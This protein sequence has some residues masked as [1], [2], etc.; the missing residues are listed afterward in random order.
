[1][2][3]MSVFPDLATYVPSHRSR[4]RWRGYDQSRLLAEAITDHLGVPSRTALT[5]TRS[6]RSQVETRDRTTCIRKVA[7]VFEASASPTIAGKK[8]LLVDDVMTTEATLRS[9]GKIINEPG[10]HYA[11][12]AMLTREL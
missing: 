9:A 6:G 5:R 8:V 12:A 1:M 2:R 7:G 11:L 10:A 4:I 3:R